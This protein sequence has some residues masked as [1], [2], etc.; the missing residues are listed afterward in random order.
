MRYQCGFA[1]SDIGVRLTDAEA[2]NAVRV[3]QSGEPLAIA[4]MR[5]DVSGGVGFVRRY[6]L[7][8]V[9]A[10]PL[11]AR[12][13]TIGC[14]LLYGKDT[15]AFDA[16]ELE[17]GRTL[18]ATV[19]L[20]LENA[21]L[22]VAAA[23]A[24]RQTERQLETTRLLI[25]AADALKSMSLADVLLKLT[26][27]VPRVSGHARV[28][29]S[30]WREELER[31]EV[32][33]SAGDA[34]VPSGLLVSLEELS[35]SALASITYEV[36]TLVDYDALEPGERGVGNVVASHLA[37]DVPL[38]SHGRLVGLLAVD[39]PGGRRDFSERE[40]RVVEGIAAQAATA[41][42]NAGLY[43]QERE[44]ARFG[45]TLAA[46]DGLVHSSLEFDEIVQVA[47]REGAAALGAES[48]G[49]SLHED[50]E[51]RFRVA[52]VHDLPADRVGVLIPDEQDTHG[53]LAM[54]TGQTQAI[55][56]TSAD[57]RVVREL[58]AAWNIRSVI[59]APLTV[60]GKAIGVVYYNYHSAAHHFG[61][62]EIDFLSRLAAS[63]STALGNARLYEAQRNVAVTLQEH[64]VHSLP[65][66]EGIG[67]AEMSLP[68]AREELIGGDFRDVVRLPDGRVL[69]L[70]GDV[71]GK[72]IAAAGLTET[73][74]GAV[75]TAAISA[76]SPDAVLDTVNRLLLLDDEHR[77]LATALLVIVDPL[78]GRGSMASAGHPPPVHITSSR[79]LLLELENG[80]PLGAMEQSFPLSD[81]ALA[82]GD[83]LVLYTDG[84]TD[85]R[86]D[87]ELFGE[88]RLLAALASCP[89]RSPQPLVDGIRAEITA[90]ADD[91]RDDIQV[92]VLRRG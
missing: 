80:M 32:V 73:I 37:L 19:S 92:L 4:D 34:P 87:G 47:L 14:L 85:A 59:C 36:A 81:F 31:L 69:A 38:V 52:Y 15:R 88:D 62:M 25:E 22:F 45:K 30:L 16:S 60:R 49:L 68:A 77:Q 5:A 18:G 58:M 64:F 90:F 41:I 2:P 86:R 75:R 40:I 27:I 71:M 55:H 66:I 61:A 28:T 70:I 21:R 65:A 11:L 20:A 44:S 83:T 50:G 54:L 78:T 46:V 10:I 12:D 48:C 29:V 74:R 63:V 1:A 8:S 67:L 53:V 82:P 89:E 51:K 9:L 84:L 39:D 42:A 7:R 35:S 72:G 79:C 24:Q 33:A 43:E 91:L 6:G 26:D 56:D 76:P 57:P 13:E 23:E 17:F 3:E